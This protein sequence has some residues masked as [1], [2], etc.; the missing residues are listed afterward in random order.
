METSFFCQVISIEITWEPASLSCQA[1]CSR[2]RTDQRKPAAA[3]RP[4]SR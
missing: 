1:S 3:G 4:E 2:S